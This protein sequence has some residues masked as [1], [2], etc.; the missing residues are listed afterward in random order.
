MI[1]PDDEAL[2]AI[3]DRALEAR[4]SSVDLE[5]RM[6]NRDGEWVWLRKR[7]ELV[8]DAATGARRLVGIAVDISDQKREAEG[9]ATADQRLRE[10]I[11]AISEAFR[12]VGFVQSSGAVQLEVSAAA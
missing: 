3:A 11:E 4:L 6:R 10:A 7:A 9:P 2:A 1:H 5:F 12:T 8:E